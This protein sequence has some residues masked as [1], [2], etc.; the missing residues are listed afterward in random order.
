MNIEVNGTRLWFDVEGPSLVPDGRG[1]RERPTVVLLHGGP[2][3]FD[4][5]YFKPDFARLS[6]VAQVVYLDLRDHG[7]SARGDPAGWS[8]ER[9]A[10]DLQGFCDHLGIVR[11]V[12]YGH[13]LGG[14]VA[15]AYA[16]RHPGHAGALVLQSTHARFD[17]GRIVE[18]FRRAGDDEVAAIA[19]RSTAATVSR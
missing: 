16:V 8:F 5:S 13:S 3:S 14:F 11:P 15:M 18:G 7:R 1:M 17:L 4:H 9:C 19:E 12:V 6:E 2:G 10:D